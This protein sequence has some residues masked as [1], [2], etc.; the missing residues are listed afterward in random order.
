MFH[1]VEV[2]CSS[3]HTLLWMAVQNFLFF[4]FGPQIY[5]FGDLILIE[6]QLILIFYERVGLKDK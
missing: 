3:S 5:F 6:D 4:Q 2:H 1:R